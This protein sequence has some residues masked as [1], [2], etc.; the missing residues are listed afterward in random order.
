MVRRHPPKSGWM[1]KWFEA[2]D[3]GEPVKLGVLLL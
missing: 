2:L 3:A 1:A